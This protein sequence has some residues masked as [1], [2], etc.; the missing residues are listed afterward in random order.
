MIAEESILTA[1]SICTYWKEVPYVNEE[2]LESVREFGIITPLFGRWKDNRCQIWLGIERLRVAEKLGIEFLPIIIRNVTDDE[3]VMLRTEENLRHKQICE[4]KPS[5]LADMIFE[6]HRRLKSQGRRTDLLQEVRSL[7]QQVNN[8]K[9]TFRPMDEKLA[10]DKETGR[11]FGLSARTVSRYLRVHS[12]SRQLKIFLDNSRITLR[13][14]VE[15]SYISKAEQS[16]IYELMCNCNDMNI[17]LEVAARLREL[18]VSGRLSNDIIESELS[19]KSYIRRGFTKMPRLFEKYHLGQYDSK[20]LEHVI[21]EA[22]QLYFN[23]THKVSW[24]D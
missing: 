15:L 24:L 8:W 14:A 5:E 19:T 4:F 23:K 21:D 17:S 22:L 10:S 18:S 2:L 20:T 6:Y 13:V 12:L 1:R 16:K 11:V 3:I 7:V 9:P